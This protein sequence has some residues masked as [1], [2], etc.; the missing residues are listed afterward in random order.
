MSVMNARRMD[1]MSFMVVFF[2]FELLVSPAWL[3]LEFPLGYWYNP[4]KA[5]GVYRFA[6][7][8][9]FFRLGGWLGKLF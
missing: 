2:L 3:V 9:R 7:L 8:L 1:A 4:P 5:F 6:E